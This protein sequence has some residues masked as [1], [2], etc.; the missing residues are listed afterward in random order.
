MP[1]AIHAIEETELDIL[2]LRQ[3]AAPATLTT[4]LYN[5]MAALQADVDPSDDALIV[6]TVFHI[7]HS[8]RATWCR[9]VVA[10]ARYEPVL[11]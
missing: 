11:V 10:G 9:E 7:L 3:D 4:T 2:D 5:L 6:A 1:T 8:G